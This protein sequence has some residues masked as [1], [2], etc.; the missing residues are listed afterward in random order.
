MRKLLSWLIRLYFAD[1]E[2]AVICTTSGQI[3]QFSNKKVI[4]SYEL[5]ENADEIT[6]FTSYNP[7]QKFYLV[8]YKR[9]LVVVKKAKPMCVSKEF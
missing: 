3:L 8:K 1:E 5:D 2:T 6:I 9:K 4:D 7:V